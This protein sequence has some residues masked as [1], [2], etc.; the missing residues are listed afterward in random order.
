[1]RSL[2]ILGITLVVAACS[3]GG[4]DGDGG[5]EDAGIDAASTAFACQDANLNGTCDASAQYCIESLSGSVVASGLC[6]PLPSDCSS[7]DCAENNAASAW[8]NA[9]PG[10]SDCAGTVSCS[11]SNA[12]ITISCLH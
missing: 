5:T 6:A 4:G 2:C 9:Y 11:Q 8:T 1:M 3:S 12:Q 10:T 7:C